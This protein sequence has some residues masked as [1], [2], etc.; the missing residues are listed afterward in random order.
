MG[1]DIAAAHAVLERTPSVLRE[2]LAGLPESATSAREGEG[3]WSAYDVVGHL[4][5][6]EETDWI[7]RARI[8]LAQGPDRRFEPFDRFRHLAQHGAQPI[9]KRLRRFAE[10]RAANLEVLHGWNLAASQLA[11]RGI[12]PEFGEVTLAQLL[13]TW[14]THDLGHLAQIARVMAKQHADEVGP[15]RAYLPVLRAR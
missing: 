11:L 8:I 7:P 1:F 5:D 10:L 9:S 6:G 4:I 12:H 3:T 13:A 14:V 2:L 15:W